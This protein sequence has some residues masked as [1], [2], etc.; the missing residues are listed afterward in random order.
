MFTGQII[1]C[2]L[3]TSACMVFTVI[4]IMN[5][6]M[7]QTFKAI[8]TESA[9]MVDAC[10]L[11]TSNAGNYY[12]L[13]FSRYINRTSYWKAGL[14]YF[15]KPYEYTPN[16]PQVSTLNPEEM[17]P[18]TIHDKGKDFYVDGG[19]YRTLA[20]NLK[21]VYWSI[22]LGGFIG[23]ESVSY[24]H[25]DVYK[26][27]TPSFSKGNNPYFCSSSLEIFSERL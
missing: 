14:S 2:L 24:T 16:L 13:S 21:S 4:N 22:G 1:G 26:R 10:L 19:Y 6:I 18:E 8:Y 9:D 12:N 20:S 11:Y 25:L 23:T 3:Y 15:E 17:I 27:Q 5:Q 7:W